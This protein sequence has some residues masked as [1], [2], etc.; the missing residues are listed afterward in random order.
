MLVDG[1]IR[2]ENRGIWVGGGGGWGCSWVV[3]R[4]LALV[5]I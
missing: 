2:G 4:Q 3:G 1:V 5:V